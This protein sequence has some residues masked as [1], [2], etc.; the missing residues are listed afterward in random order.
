MATM[1]NLINWN[2]SEQW[3]SRVLFW[4]M[5]Y[6]NVIENKNAKTHYNKLIL[7]ALPNKMC[8]WERL[9]LLLSP[10]PPRLNKQQFVNSTT[11]K[12]LIHSSSLI[13]L[14]S[15]VC[16]VLFGSCLVL[17]SRK[18]EKKKHLGLKKQTNTERWL[19]D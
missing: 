4:K 6:L 19:V 3:Q 8:G 18:I 14:C 7:A 5:Q 1:H 9:L 11:I 15:F 13:N 12:L 2:N 16:S 17:H 10:C